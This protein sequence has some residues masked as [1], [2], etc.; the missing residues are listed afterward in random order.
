MIL[1]ITTYKALTGDVRNYLCFYREKLFRSAT[2]IRLWEGLPCRI[3]SG[4][5]VGRICIGMR[6]M[7]WGGSI[8]GVGSAGAVPEKIFEK[9]R[10]K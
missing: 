5:Q 1:D 10:L 7:R 6:R 9:T 2:T 4:W 3:R 8:R